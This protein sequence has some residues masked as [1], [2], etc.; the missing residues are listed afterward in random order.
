MPIPED[1]PSRLSPN[2][3]PQ[4]IA[5]PWA[6]TGP[7]ARLQAHVAV[8]APGI[9]ARQ[10]LAFADAGPQAP[11]CCCAQLR[12]RFGGCRRQQ[13]SFYSGVSQDQ[14][15]RDAHLVT[16]IPGV[17][18]T[19]GPAGSQLLPSTPQANTTAFPLA[20]HTPLPPPGTA[21]PA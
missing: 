13:E 6:G 8:R 10:P 12:A 1:G 21:C 9:G 20:L 3:I 16:F 2:A 19:S 7:T 11:L 5:E 18:P 14:A 17:I 15:L 4:G